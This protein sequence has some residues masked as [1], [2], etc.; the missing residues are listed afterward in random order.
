MRP[1]RALWDAH[2][3]SAVKR[4]L[5]KKI[6]QP[7]LE[8]GCTDG[9]NSFILLG[10]E[11][12]YNFDD[13]CDLPNYSNKNKS[14]D[15]FQNIKN[16]HL[17]PIKKPAN[18]EIQIGTSWKKA[19]LIRAK[20]LNLYKNLYLVKIGKA[21]PFKSDSA[22][23]IWAPNLFWNKPSHLN[24]IINEFKRILQKNGRI[25]LIVPDKSQKTHEFWQ[26]LEGHS[27]YYYKELNRGIIKNLTLNAKSTKAWKQLFR[28]NELK[29]SKHIKF[30][31]ALVGKVYQLG[32]RPMFPVLL[33][34]Y[35]KLE[36]S[37]QKGLRHLKRRWI[38]S[39]THFMI[40]LCSIPE[41]GIHGKRLWHAFELQHAGKKRNF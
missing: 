24:K 21:L 29:V 31:P 17:N 13:Y 8:Y 22:A 28:R 27:K 6:R 38:K 14:N 40:P 4:L 3:L 41:K 37:N 19:H 20:R 2:E 5:G 25:V 18:I 15:F 9:L 1:E 26:S 30:L 11:A 23:T 7:F 32:F 33:K 34:I 36:K 16:C 10:G 12:N 39:I 35:Q